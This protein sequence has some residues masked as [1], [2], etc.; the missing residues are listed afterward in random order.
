MNDSSS[1]AEHLSAAIDGEADD[2]ALDAAIDRLRDDAGARRQWLQLHRLG[3][4]LRM[5]GAPTLDDEAFLARFSA[6]LEAEPHHLPVAAAPGRDAAVPLSDTR[7]RRLARFVPVAVAAGIVA[8]AWTLAPAP[9]VHRA[10]H[11]TLTEPA[12]H[13]ALH[14]PAGDA[15]DAL[16]LDYLVAHQQFAPSSRLQGVAPYVRSVGLAAPQPAAQP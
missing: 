2:A 5:P 1:K 15:G 7:L 3:D 10:A 9:G 6:R 11:A 16:P 8:L 13:A 14:V 12:V 4:A